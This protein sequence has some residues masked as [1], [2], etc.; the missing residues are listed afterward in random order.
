MLCNEVA[1]TRVQTAREEARCKE[2]D[3]GPN[4]PTL[5]EHIVEY[6]LDYKIDEVPACE[7]LRAYE[8]GPEGIE[9]YLERTKRT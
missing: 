9:Q 3:E 4:A 8:P 1:G 2:V 6:K 5:D 7:P